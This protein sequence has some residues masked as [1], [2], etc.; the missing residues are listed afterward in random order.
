MLVICVV[1]ADKWRT[2]LIKMPDDVI[3]ALDIGTRTIIGVVEYKGNDFQILAAEKVVHE[4]RAMVDTNSWYRQGGPGAAKV[5]NALKR[6]WYVFQS[7][8]AAAGRVLK[9]CQIKAEQAIE[10]ER[11]IDAQLISAI[12]MDSIQKAQLEIEKEFSEGEKISII[13]SDTV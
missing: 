4:S 2:I 3:F 7:V 13:A 6:G 10:E 11:E 5:V 8:I 9:T 1:N 12:E